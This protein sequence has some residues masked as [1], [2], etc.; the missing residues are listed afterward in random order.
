MQ[1]RWT[2]GLH[3][4]QTSVTRKILKVDKCFT[5]ILQKI[6]IFTWGVPSMIAKHSI[7]MM[8]IWL[9]WVSIKLSLISSLLPLVTTFQTT[10][11]VLFQ[12]SLGRGK[13][14]CIGLR[15]RIRKR[16]ISDL[17]SYILNILISIM[18]RVMITVLFSWNST[19]TSIN[20]WKKAAR[21]VLREIDHQ[22]CFFPY[23]RH[24]T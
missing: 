12:W 13:T 18:Q 22:V 4:R 20:W 3:L 15:W 16:S 5:W 6:I 14:H 17:F 23:C 2:F 11:F 7:F 8:K 21:E 1:W 24:H 9:R 10:P 19:I